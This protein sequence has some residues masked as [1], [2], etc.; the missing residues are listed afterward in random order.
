MN[1]MGNSVMWIG[2]VIIAGLLV[3][4]SNGRKW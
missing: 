4:I 1:Y 3:Y 2:V